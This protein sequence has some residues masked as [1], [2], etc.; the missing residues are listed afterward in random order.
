[1]SAQN[2]DKARYGRERK[3]KIARRLRNR[4][5]KKALMGPAAVVPPASKPAV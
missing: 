1:M 5:M 4:E 2:G 3:Q